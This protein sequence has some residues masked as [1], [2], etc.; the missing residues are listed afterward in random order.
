MINSSGFGG[1][2][3]VIYSGGETEN[4][5]ATLLDT[6]NLVGSEVNSNGSIGRSL[7]E[8]FDDPTDT[9]LP[10]MKLGVNHKT[11]RNWSLISWLAQDDPAS[12]A[13]TLEWEPKPRRLVIKR[14]G[15]P[16]WSSG[17]QL[18]SSKNVS[19]FE[20]IHPTKGQGYII[21]TNVEG[22]YFIYSHDTEFDSLDQERSA[23]QL[24]Y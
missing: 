5:S 11:G 21:N 7:W 15:V 1:D 24:Q 10:G 20:Y 12:G 8:S 13:F 22:Q 2:P 3:F 18:S 6:G 16:Y 9:L 4:T 17:L 14:R 23:W 19:L